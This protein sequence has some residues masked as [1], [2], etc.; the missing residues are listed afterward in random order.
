MWMSRVLMPAAL[1]IAM[2]VTVPASVPLAAA[3]VAER[4]PEPRFGWV[5]LE[6]MERVAIQHQV[7]IERRVT[8]R[9][10]PLSAVSRQQL[11]SQGARVQTRRMAERPRA[12]CLPLSS[13]RAVQALESNRLVFY[14]QD[15]QM[16][17]AVMDNACSATDFYS[18]FYVEPAGDGLLCE[19]RDMLQARSGARCE[20]AGL[21]QLVP[22]D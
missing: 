17:S 18:G 2:M 7:R 3:P 9:V 1:L 16:V 12:E 13:I 22:V 19:Q 15:R 6:A 5:A 14:L 10:S 20:I 8:I 4:G 11:I 21:R